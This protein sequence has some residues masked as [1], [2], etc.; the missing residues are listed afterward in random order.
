MKRSL[1]LLFFFLMT[2]IFATAQNLSAKV[3]SPD[4]K[5]SKINFVGLKHTKEDVLYS[6]LKDYIGKTP[7]DKLLSQIETDLQARNLFSEIKL[8][9]VENNDEECELNIQLKEK[10]TFIPL[11]FVMVSSSGFMAG[12]FLMNMNAFGA[13]DLIV[14][15][16]LFSK[17]TIFGMG[18][19]VHQPKVDRPGY[20]LFTEVKKSTVKISD[21]D[22]N[23][24]AELDCFSIN[25]ITRITFKLGKYNSI[26]A[27]L[28]YKGRFYDDD[29]VD[30]YNRNQFSVLSS[31]NCGIQDWNGVFLSASSISFDADV[32]V[33]NKTRFVEKFSVSGLLQQP[34]LKDLRLN[35]AY[36]GGII[37]NGLITDYVGE[38][39][40]A[41]T[42]LNDGFVTDRIAGLTT[43]LEYAALKL[44]MGVFSVYGNYETVFAKD[45]D[46]SLVYSYGV[47]AGSKIYLSK[48]A[49]PA[50]SF[51]LN[52]NIPKAKFAYAI[53][54]G[55]SM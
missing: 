27:G 50:F 15:G 6:E 42:I 33:D 9:V 55:M 49:I 19:Y 18:M 12:G 2:Q 46:D 29:Y 36:G 22:D 45:L 23:R 35:I 41:V 51:G 3:L 4:A 1:F 53:S 44:N 34:L 39:T 8:E 17:D 11:P 13:G 26:N 16:G 25:P 28:G 20:N 40:G 37:I 14:G 38:S 32:S 30:L 31:W 43:G 7:D 47:T 5:L 21:Y 24:V 52:Y 54:I 48:L 10:I